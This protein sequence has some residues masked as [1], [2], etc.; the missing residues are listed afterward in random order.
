[1]FYVKNFISFSFYNCTKLGSA[2]NHE[3]ELFMQI[4]EKKYN[5]SR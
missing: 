3:L 4:I 5:L 1:M 2:Y